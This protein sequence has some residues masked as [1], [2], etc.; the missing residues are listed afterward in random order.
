MWDQDLAA[1][2]FVCTLPRDLSV[3]NGVPVGHRCMTLPPRILH[4]GVGQMSHSLV[5]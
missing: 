2:I 5:Q 3:K 1:L 4:Y